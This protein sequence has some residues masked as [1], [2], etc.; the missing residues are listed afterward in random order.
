[1]GN[2][3]SSQQGGGQ[4]GLVTP[5]TGKARD[6]VLEAV[7]EEKTLNELTNYAIDYCHS[8]G[9]VALWNER[10]DCN[11]IS[12]TPPIA[13]LASSFPAELF[14]KAKAVQQTLSELYFRIS[15]DHDFL[16]EA[17]RDVVK[18]DKWMAKQIDMM[19]QVRK[20]GFHQKL[21][22]QFQRADYM[23]HWEGQ[24]NKM[25][26][27]QVEVN[28]GQVGGPGCATAMTKLHKKMLEKAENLLGGPLASLATATQPENRP[29]R[30]MA[31]TLY[32]AWKLFNDPKA[33]IVFMNQ[34][35][36]FPVCHFEQLQFVQYEVEKLARK[37]G[38]HLNV[39]RMPISETPQ[40]L[41]LDETDFSLY[42]D[43]NK[44]VALVH[45]AYGYLPDHYPTE[46]EWKTRTDMERST[47]IISPDI[48]LSLAGSKKIQQV[49]A[50]PGVI[51][52]F[53][54]GQT[55]KIAELRST[56][57][58]LWGLENDDE[59]I[60]AVIQDAI[61]SPKK[62]VM[63]AQLGAGKGNYF[64]EDMARMLRE[65]SVEERGAYILQQKIWPVVTKNYMK[66]P[67]QAPILE[68]IVSELGIY[69]SFIG[70]DEDGGKVLWNRV[71]GYLCRSK[72][73]F[74]NQGGVSDGGGVV[75]S[76]ML[77]PEAQFH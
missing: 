10:K 11:D 45:M 4:N 26:L 62:Y 9:N 41:R 15:L 39:M 57:T 32:H 36:M 67:F 23:S 28:I 35:D 49:L 53:L 27:K 14:E 8:I 40:R 75:D 31:E 6:Y 68:N 61:Q 60:R 71:E 70:A 50:K 3:S 47:A 66:R 24:G 19:E 55:E 64:D 1:M 34:P 43:G 77:F 52:R 76:V 44:R 18:S 22:F 59:N 30:G 38:F 17:Y 2:S 21:V 29:R 5:G 54:P 72:A 37:E 46:K 51:E 65:M 69:G 58:G 56:F 73:H 42:A 48:R 13:L 20:E 7:P 63:K 33:V 74:V 12:V 25:E 16:V